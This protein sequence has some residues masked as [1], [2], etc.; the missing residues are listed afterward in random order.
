MNEVANIREHGVAVFD[1]LGLGLTSHPGSPR[2]PILFIFGT[3]KG[4]NVPHKLPVSQI[5][6]A[7]LFQNTMPK[8]GWWR[9]IWRFFER[10]LYHCCKCFWI[11]ITSWVIQWVCIQH[12]LCSGAVICGVCNCTDWWTMKCCKTER[13]PTATRLLPKEIWFYKVCRT[14]PILFVIG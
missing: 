6:H 9:H 4:Y 5:V 2:A 7:S 11:V 13:I 8:A 12:M 10:A 14:F 1:P 3:N